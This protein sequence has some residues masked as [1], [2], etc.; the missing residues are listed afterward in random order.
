M[1]RLL[2][3]T[4]I[5]L[6]LS[7][8][9]TLINYGFSGPFAQNWAKGF[10]VAFLI[11]PVALRLIPFVA[12]GARKVL[13]DRSVL[14]LRCTVAVCVAI[15][16]EGLIALVVT[17]AQ[18]GMAVGWVAMWGGVFLKALPVGLLIGFTMTFIVQPR[19]QKLAMAAR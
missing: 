5:A 6:L 14:L 7:L 12:K 11:I 4:C 18:Q 2:I 10:V 19:M 1:L 8:V 13:G 3:Q 9:M 15:M 17:L 16:M